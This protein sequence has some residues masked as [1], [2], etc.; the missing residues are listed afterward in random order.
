MGFGQQEQVRKPMEYSIRDTILL[1]IFCPL[2]TVLCLLIRISMFSY[3][4]LCSFV[5]EDHS[6]LTFTNSI[7][8]SLR[9]II[10]N[11]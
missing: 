9:L 6:T 8:V 11:W 10:S 4:P 1:S 7:R 3:V 5:V 2:L